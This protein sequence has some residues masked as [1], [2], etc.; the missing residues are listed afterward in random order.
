MKEEKLI[1]KLAQIRN[2]KTGKS[3]RP[4]SSVV[5]NYITFPKSP[6]KWPRCIRRAANGERE[7]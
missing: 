7:K 4:I 2:L 5:S 3:Q 6:Q 1:K